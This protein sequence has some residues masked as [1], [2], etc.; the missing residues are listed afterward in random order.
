MCDA[1][2]KL[3]IRCHRF[4][5]FLWQNENPLSTCLAFCDSMCLL[6]LIAE[7]LFA[8]ALKESQHSDDPHENSALEVYTQKM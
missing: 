5:T 1:V 8:T 4:L 3:L 7:T 2:V 6:W